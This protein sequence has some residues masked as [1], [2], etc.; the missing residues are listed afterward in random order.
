MNFRGAV[1]RNNAP[2]AESARSMTKELLWACQHTKYQELEVY[3]AIMKELLHPDVKQFLSKYYSLFSSDVNKSSAQAYDY[4]LE[5][6]NRLLS[7]HLEPKRGIPS[8]ED[9]VRATQLCVPIRMLHGHV[10]APDIV[11]NIACT[12]IKA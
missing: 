2:L 11:L 9:W 10:I 7:I 1:R 12:P 3:D 4:L 6:L 5:E 8:D